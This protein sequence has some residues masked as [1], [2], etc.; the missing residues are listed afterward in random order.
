MVGPNLIVT[1]GGDLILQICPEGWGRNGGPDEGRV[2]SLTTMILYEGESF[3]RS[4]VRKVSLTFHFWN[5]SGY[6]EMVRRGRK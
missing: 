5:G 1:V 6:S 3:G 4:P 2:V